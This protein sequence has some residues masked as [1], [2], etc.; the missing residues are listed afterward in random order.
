MVGEEGMKAGGD[1]SPRDE[2][3]TGG[4]RFTSVL[5]SGSWL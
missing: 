2:T 1:A 3:L 5:G 4:Q